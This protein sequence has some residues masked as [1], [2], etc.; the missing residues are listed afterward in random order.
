[1][2][3]INMKKLIL[4]GVCLV[5]VI[6]V[7]GCVQETS[8]TQNTNNYDGSKEVSTPS[9]SQQKSVCGDNTCSS[10]ESQST[11]CIDCSCSTG[12]VC[13]PS[14]NKCE[15]EKPKITFSYQVSA[16]PYSVSVLYAMPTETINKDNP[17]IT[18]SVSNSGG[19]ASSV[20]VKT[21]LGGY[22]D[23]YTENIGTVNKGDNK[24]FSTTPRVESGALSLTTDTNVPLS[25]QLI[26]KDS[27]G[28]E[29]KEDYSKDV[30]IKGRNTFSWAYPELTSAWVTSDDPIIRNF[31]TESTQGLAPAYA[32]DD[33]APAVKR[34]FREVEAFGVRYASDPNGPFGDYLQFPVET[35]ST[36]SGDCDD[37]A[38]L[39]AGLLSAVGIKSG[40]VLTTGHAY[41]WFEANGTQYSLEGTMLGYGVENIITPLSQRLKENDVVVNTQQEWNSGIKRINLPT[42]PAVSVPS[43]SIN[44]QNPKSRLL[45]IEGVVWDIDIAFTNTGGQGYRCLTVYNTDKSTGYRRNEYVL[46]TNV[47]GGSS[48]KTVTLD[49]DA[50]K[51]YT[52]GYYVNRE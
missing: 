23:W 26:Y 47:P 32:Q 41:T 7:S 4:L 10:D 34:I 15:L 48:T 25:I 18:C 49:G 40:V 36:R 13:N 24:Q 38:V 14:L 9:T 19:V 17:M 30:V 50:F 39:F 46:C 29:Y 12:Y 1:M 2:Y 33:I 21:K 16:N 28:Q 44:L 22:S 8:P 52:F 45:V 37:M 31:A 6:I 35:L 3:V 20:Q 11:C 42:P 5:F 51:E 27:S 43:I